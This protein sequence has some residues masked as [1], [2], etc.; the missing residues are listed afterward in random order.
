MLPL[1]I[2]EVDGRQSSGTTPETDLQKIILSWFQDYIERD[3]DDGSPCSRHQTL[4]TISPQLLAYISSFSS[5]FLEFY[6]SQLIILTDI[7]SINPHSTGTSNYDGLFDCWLTLSH[8]SLITY[9]TCMTVV[10]KRN[11]STGVA[12]ETIWTKLLRKLTS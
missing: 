1:W 12:M 10:K 7:Y 11:V 6:I 2:S 9:Q 5:A 8:A 4:F 3:I